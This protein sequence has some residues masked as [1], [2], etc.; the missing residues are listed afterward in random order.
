MHWGTDREDRN[1]YGT[2]RCKPNMQ[3][4]TPSCCT[5]GKRFGATSSP[6][7]AHSWGEK[8]LH[9]GNTETHKGFSGTEA[10]KTDTYLMQLLYSQ[11]LMTMPPRQC[12]LPSLCGEY[13]P[14]C[15]LPSLCG[16]CIGIGLG[17]GT[18]GFGFGHCAGWKF[19]DTGNR[20]LPH[21]PKKRGKTSLSGATQQCVDCESLTP[22]RGATPK[23]GL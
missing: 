21:L 18:H 4:G 23:R 11:F 22:T 20:P 2:Q 3:L 7:S 12:L 14:G 16:R 13:F 8:E 15:L 9:T 19:C 10:I 17:F 5:C 6:S 1:V